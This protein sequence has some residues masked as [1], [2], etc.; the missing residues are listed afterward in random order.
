MH[1]PQS[2][3]ALIPAQ[4]STLGVPPH[5]R[6]DYWQDMICGPVVPLE[7][8]LPDR[9]PFDASL[10]WWQLGNL[11]LSEIQASPHRVQRLPA[12]TEMEH[13]VLDF[14]IEGNCYVEQ[15]GRRVGIS[16]GSGVICNTARP[17]SQ[18]FPE[19]CKLAVLTFPRELLSRQVAA[20]DRGTA[21]DLA[22]RSQLFPLLSAY[23][24]QLIT[25][26]PSLVPGTIQVVEQH[27]SDLL[28]STIGESLSQEPVPLS[29]LKVATLIRVH[30][31]IESNLHQSALTPETVANALRVSTRYLNQLLEAEHI[32]LG[33]L[34]L[35]KRLE[36][37]ASALRNQ[38]MTTRSITTLALTY[39]F[40]DLTHFSKAFRLRYG[41][42]AREFRTQE[43]RQLA[44]P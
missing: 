20:V 43:N 28:C 24:K 21:I 14:V 17:Y 23:V 3:P 9:K 35:R 41:I 1:S 27:L 44:Q 2:I 4:L 8:K 6:V 39:G 26:A 7:I 16:P 15:D 38:N 30:A 19:P 42:S 31:Y 32:S 34:I 11:R 36:A 10:S 12:K 22:H 5:Q 13:L 18:Y 29:D 25:Q 33:R 37:V 40:N